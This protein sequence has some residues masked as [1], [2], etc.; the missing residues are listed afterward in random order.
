MAE[1]DRSRSTGRILG[2]FLILLALVVI[3]GAVV[4]TMRPEL[5][6]LG[7]ARIVD[8]VSIV[9]QDAAVAGG[10]WRMISQWQGAGEFQ[11]AG[12]LFLVE[13]KAIPGWET[14]AAVVLKKGEMA[15]RSKVFTSPRS[16]PSRPS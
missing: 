9:P 16:I 13:F 12:N 7:S 6:S 14:P 5:F 1:M 2:I 11:E 3:G 8:R 10:Q 4:L 15:P